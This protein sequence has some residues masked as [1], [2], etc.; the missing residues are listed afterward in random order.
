MRVKRLDELRTH[1]IAR[2]HPPEVIDNAYEK[3]FQPS[4]RDENKEK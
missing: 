4:E 1:L 2:D 3:L